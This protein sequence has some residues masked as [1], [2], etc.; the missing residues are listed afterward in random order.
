MRYA[1]YFAPEPTSLLHDLGSRWLGRDAFTGEQR[2]QPSVA[3][4][5]A[6]TAEP[7]RYGFHATLKP[8][9]AL[10]ADQSVRTLSTAIASIAASIAAFPVRLTVNR[11]DGFLALQPASRSPQLEDLAARCVRELDSFRA[12]L[13]DTEMARR[14]QA[15]LSSRQN[16][17]L[18]SW[19]YPYVLDDFRFHI[20]LSQRLG[21]EESGLDVAAKVH[22]AQ[23]LAE[24]IHVGSVTLFREAG[25][26]SAFEAIR[27]FP[28]SAPALEPTP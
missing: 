19:G 2:P 26:G 8:P 28:F 14:Q 27:I 6:A 18:M 11:L 24:Q 17:N 1:I 5:E 7:R 20:T 13:S 15:P 9:F 16:A 4:I 21:P 12:E 23:V 25:P 22:F 10:R 3:G